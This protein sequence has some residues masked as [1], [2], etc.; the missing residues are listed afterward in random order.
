[1]H[2]VR[3]RMSFFLVFS[4]ALAM[5]ASLAFAQ[6]ESATIQG[7]VKDSS[8]AVLPG[9][10]V[11]AVHV[12]TGIQYQTVSNET[13]FFRLS[14]IQRGEYRVTFSAKGFAEQIVQPVQ[15]DANDLR[16]LT[17]TMV[18][19]GQKTEIQVSAESPLTDTS[20]SEIS[21]TI[22][23]RK[24]MDLPING[25]DFT[26]LA[27]LTPGVVATYSN[28]SSLT[29]NGMSSE[30][31][32]N[33][34]LLDGS[35]ATNIEDNR[36][37]AGAERGPRLQTGSVEG[38]QEFKVSEG[39]Y[40]AEVGRSA[41]AVIQITSKSGS[42]KFHGDLFE[43]VRNDMFDARNFFDPTNKLPFHLNQFGG[44]LGGPIIKNKTFFFVNYEGSR[45]NIGETG[46]GTMPNPALLTNVP[47][48]LQPVVATF[49]KPA[50][51]IDA[52]TAQ[53][54]ETGSAIT[55]ENVFAVRIDHNFSDNDRIF[56]RYSFNQ[57]HV[58]GPAFAL[59]N[60]YLGTDQ[61][62]DSTMRSQF[63][64]I[65]HT[66]V[67]T[68]SLVNEFRF[69][70]N[71]KNYELVNGGT[72]GIPEITISGYAFI[73]GTLSSSH[74]TSTSVSFA[75]SVSLI[76]GRHAMRFGVDL[77][78]PESSNSNNGFATVG[79]P[80]LAGFLKNQASY[81]LLM[82][83]QSWL[84]FQNWNTGYYFQ[85]DWKVNNRLTLNLGLRYEYNTVLSEKDGNVSNYAGGTGP[86]LVGGNFTSNG[87]PLYQPNKNNWGPRV[88]FA[89]DPFGNG[90][91]VIRG[92][93]GI[94]HSIIAI[95]TS[96]V[97][98]SNPP[99]PGVYY[100]FGST[101]NP[102]GLPIPNPS[103]PGAVTYPLRPVSIN[104]DV[105]EGYTNQYS[106]TIQH[107]FG[108]STT[109]QVGYLGYEAHHLLRYRNV[110]DI[111][112]TTFLRPD[113][114]Y[115]NILTYES[116]GNANYNSMQV[117]LN[118]RF[119]N[120]LIYGLAYVWSHSI[121]NV[122]TVASPQN[123]LDMLDERGNADNDARHNFSAH[124]S[125]TLPLKRWLPASRLTEGWQINGI[126]SARSG[127]PL[128]VLLGYDNYG[129]YTYYQRPD[130][131]PGVSV[132]GSPNGN[133][134]FINPAAFRDPALGKFGNA[135]RNIA[136]GPAFRQVDLSLFKDT[137]IH[138]SQ[139]LQFRWEVFNVTNTPNFSNYF[140]GTTYTLGVA[141][142]VNP[143]LGVGSQTFGRSIGL[144]TS[145]QMQFAIKYIF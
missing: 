141:G 100:F 68:T 22:G 88:G 97:A 74:T 23:V 64:N 52:N 46:V 123:S 9:A 40:S 50:R 118:R 110:N 38:I 87:A 37:S 122:P 59:Y 128:T 33:N 3:E 69:G 26:R 53:I 92:G 140:V 43:F 103:A 2:M 41:G 116:A 136:V 62:Q 76:R 39:T 124:F 73:L 125:Y 44:T 84:T 31:S 57:G 17:V 89:Y 45:Q 139:I 25:R 15:V 131:V 6:S 11:R 67:F 35:D 51:I 60:G 95:T 98:I 105:K 127:N 142:T 117:W 58:G 111:D 119:G 65:S 77:R 72:G 36:P 5:A 133:T 75:D 4:L 121:D 71:R 108:K 109:L 132:T 120:N 101:T 61:Q 70:L 85:D 106:L 55:D 81:A 137:K 96:E 19:E 10:A 12:T 94:Y 102:V 14:P 13:G 115:S 48:V 145:R 79:Y 78:R 112:R 90:K 29:F 1:M 20:T 135:G 21:A 49:P 24:M 113:P 66:H 27:I 91:T 28:I 104:P 30:L 126:A 138:E 80:N 129:N 86:N 16:D 42:N 47:S 99:G 34:F 114:R 143:N 63:F 8:G 144:G 134:G 18:V 54:L 32:G 130:R 83:A 107:Q 93:F 82:P 7:I 56:G